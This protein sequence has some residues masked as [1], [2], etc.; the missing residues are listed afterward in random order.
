MFSAR[1]A[2]VSSALLVG[3]AVQL[4]LDAGAVS[5]AT[6]ANYTFI[7]MGYGDFV[8]NYDNT[9]RT[10]GGGSQLSNSVDWP[11]TLFF[12]NNAE[13]DKVKGAVGDVYQSYGLRKYAILRDKPYR[14]GTGGGRWDEDG[15]KKDA[16][17]SS[18]GRQNRHFRVYGVEASENSERGVDRLYNREWG[19][20]VFATTHLDINECG[21]GAKEFGYSG[22]AESRVRSVF[23]QKGYRVYPNCCNAYNEELHRKQGGDHVWDNDGNA[24]AVDIP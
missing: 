7:D 3:M 5:A 24:S 1:L 22:Y 18:H 10:Y 15:G 21:P 20:Y 11:L 17:C 9:E 14:R 2:K 16:I 19:Y 4:M 8:A 12:F 23:Q 6:T 13:V